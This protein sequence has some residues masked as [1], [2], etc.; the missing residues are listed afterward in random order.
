MDEQRVIDLMRVFFAEM[1]TKIVSEV[2]SSVHDAG[3]DAVSDESSEKETI[4]MGEE[5]PSVFSE[6]GRQLNLRNGD[7]ILV[8]FDCETLY[9]ESKVAEDKLVKKLALTSK[10]VDAFIDKSDILC[11]FK[12]SF[13]PYYRYGG[14]LSLIHMIDAQLV[15]KIHLLL[16][17]KIDWK[18]ATPQAIMDD[19]FICSWQQQ[20][21]ANAYQEGLKALQCSSRLEDIRFE[22]NAIDFRVSCEAVLKVSS[23]KWSNA[24]GTSILNQVKEM[25]LTKH[26]KEKLDSFNSLDEFWLEYTDRVMQLEMAAKILDIKQPPK[27]NPKDPKDPPK[28]PKNPS[29]KHEC[30]LCK[31]PH[32]AVNREGTLVTCPEVGKNPAKYKAKADEL[33]AAR[34]KSFQEK[35][36]EKAAAPTPKKGGVKAVSTAVDMSVP[37]ALSEQLFSPAPVVTLDLVHQ[38]DIVPISA[39]LDG[40]SVSNIVSLDLYLNHFSTVP[41]QACLE[42][43]SLYSSTGEALQIMGVLVV[44]CVGIQLLNGVRYPRSDCMLQFFV[45]SNA[46]DMLVNN[47]TI[48]NVLKCDNTILAAIKEASRQHPGAKV[49]LVTRGV[50]CS[51]LSDEVF[52]AL[53]S[54]HNAAEG[55]IGAG[56]LYAQ[57]N[58]KFPS[59]RVTNKM[60]RTFIDLCPRC[61]KDTKGKTYA[62][63]HYVIKD[64]M[65]E[66]L[67]ADTLELRVRG[68][69][70]YILVLVHHASRFCVLTRLKGKKA[71]HIAKALLTANTYLPFRHVVLQTD[72]GTEYLNSVNNILLKTLVAKRFQVTNIKALTRRTP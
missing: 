52:S 17:S 51:E 44:P 65:Y 9:R 31:G 59:L 26:L 47:Y 49:N 58:R 43:V 32:Y 38:Q 24:V 55:H 39:C 30:P 57:V 60:C 67:F 45:C 11:W 70:Y 10:E 54:L 13:V 48:D 69:V 72:Q 71:K 20:H 22:F 1:Q 29:P 50:K 40:G 6:G 2:I 63:L 62:A 25:R 7:R 5:D 15:L 8:P 12:K 3:H 34:A 23:V 33:M 41:L 19:V 4:I 56:R 35:S 27:P 28:D 37:P 46:S 42:Q 36:A 53:A 66:Y 61:Q 18:S 16:G 14:Q 21:S 64:D 68:V